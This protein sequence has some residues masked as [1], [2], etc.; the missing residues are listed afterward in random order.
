MSKSIRTFKTKWFDKWAKKEKLSNK[1]LLNA[2]T[3]MN[4][5]LFDA[6]LGKSIFKKRVATQGQG[7]SGG[8]RT[9]IA[10]K[11]NDKAFFVYGFR[12]SAK[13]NITTNELKALQIL[14]ENLLEHNEQM[15]KQLVELKELTE[16][17]HNE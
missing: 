15:L 8:F 6:D 12:K 2:I 17:Q 13:N 1:Q 10:Y 9:L 11:L 3:E 4:N 7:K 14:A 16:V 5:G